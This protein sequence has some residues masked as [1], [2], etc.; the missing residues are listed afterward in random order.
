MKRLIESPEPASFAQSLY[1]RLSSSPAP[2][3]AG[4]LDRD[5]SRGPDDTERM[6]DITREEFNAKIETIE[7]KM[8]A[9]VQAVTSKID[10]FIAAQDERDKRLDLILA[11]IS[12]DSGEAKSSISSMKGTMIVTAIS[13]VLAIVIGVAS[14]NTSLASNMMSAFQLGVNLTD[15][16]DQPR[17]SPPPAPPATM[18][19]PA[20]QASPGT[21]PSSTK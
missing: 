4:P 10:G 13:T 9:R 5:K 16:E 20:P 12:K 15:Q 8:D 18:H 1:D 11:Q 7:V 6:N 21:P 17:D 19:P 14:F 2:S 3:V